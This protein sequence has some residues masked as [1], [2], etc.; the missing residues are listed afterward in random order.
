MFVANK[1]IFL[2]LIVK[3]NLKMMGRTKFPLV[4]LDD[5]NEF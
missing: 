1:I 4:F 2:Y 5:M 3:R